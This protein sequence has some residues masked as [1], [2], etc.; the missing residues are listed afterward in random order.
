[1]SDGGVSDDPGADAWEPIPVINKATVPVGD[2][3]NPCTL[4]EWRRRELSQ[5]NSAAHQAAGNMMFLMRAV[6]LGLD[7]IK[8]LETCHHRQQQTFG[9]ADAVGMDTIL[10]A[11]R[12]ELLRTGNYS[13]DDKLVKRLNAEIERIAQGRSAL[14]MASVN[15]LN[16]VRRQ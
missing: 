1:M 13:P 7:V 16:N 6:S 15:D 3:S 4:R 11:E 10:V 2:E 8:V 12:D 14:S 5:N 9:G